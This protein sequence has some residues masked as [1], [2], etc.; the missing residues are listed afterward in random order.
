[1]DVWFLTRARELMRIRQYRV[2]ESAEQAEVEQTFNDCMRSLCDIQLMTGVGILLSAYSTLYTRDGGGGITAYH[3]QIAVYLAWLSNLTHTTGLTFLRKYLARH[4]TELRWRT[5]SMT[6]LFLLVFV[7]LQPLV[8]FNW[9]V[10]PLESEAQPA[11]A[12]SFAFCFFRLGVVRAR[13]RDQG[14]RLGVPYSSGSSAILSMYL[15]TF[16]FATRMAKLTSRHSR[17]VLVAIRR[18][19]S[20]WN[21][22]FINRMAAASELSGGEEGRPV[23][24]TRAYTKA[25]LGI[26][27]LL[28]GRLYTDLFTSMLSEVSRVRPNFTCFLTAVVHSQVY[29]AI[30]AG[31]WVTARILMSRGSAKVAEDEF[32]FGQVLAIFLLASPIIT[33]FVALWPLRSTLL[34]LRQPKETA[35]GRLSAPNYISLRASC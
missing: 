3:W 6:V 32:T 30:V 16:N 35:P 14:I 31:T 19:A 27:I 1:V 25:R 28:T 20:N 23:L 29:W 24:S 15:L 22:N 33:T 7:S 5:V 12:S 17:F 8:Y 4:K 21:K 18:R 34:S 26:A 10:V 11:R 13:M 9:D 2:G